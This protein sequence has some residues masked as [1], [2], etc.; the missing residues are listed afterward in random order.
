MSGAG[1]VVLVDDAS[2]MAQIRVYKD[3][4]IYDLIAKQITG[5]SWTYH[6]IRRAFE[7]PIWSQLEMKN[8]RSWHRADQAKWEWDC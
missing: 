5:K 8:H 6:L 1:P 2:V 3:G 4:I 7:V